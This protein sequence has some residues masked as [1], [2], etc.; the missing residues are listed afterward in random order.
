M[1]TKKP[2]YVVVSGG[3]D[4]IH[5]G[6]LSYLEA[7]RSL[8]DK[9]LVVLNSDAFLKKKKGYFVLPF[10]TRAAILKAIKWVDEVIGC[11]DQDQTVRETIKYLHKQGKID[12]FAKGG[13]RR[14]VEIPERKICEELGIEM[15]FGVGGYEKPDSSSWIGQ[16]V[17]EKIKKLEQKE[18]SA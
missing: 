15:R 11:C 6:H 2:F 18:T 5:K 12:V 7:A 3:F 17:Y 16:R 1:K 4:P 14:L 10:E 13:D 9:L 8:G